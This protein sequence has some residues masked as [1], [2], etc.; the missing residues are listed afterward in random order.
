MGYYCLMFTKGMKNCGDF[1]TCDYVQEGKEVKATNTNTEFINSPG[2][3]CFTTCKKP[4]CGQQNCGETYLKA[5]QYAGVFYN[6]HSAKI[7]LK[8]SP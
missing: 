8:G 2:V 1:S 4:R 5:H 7:R 3:I 6:D